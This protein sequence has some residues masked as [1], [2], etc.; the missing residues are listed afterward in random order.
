[1]RIDMY[2]YEYIAG[3]IIGREYIVRSWCRYI[4]RSMEIVASQQVIEWPLI[5]I[6]NNIMLP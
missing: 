5:F 2:T 6:N 4:A 1:M 3:R